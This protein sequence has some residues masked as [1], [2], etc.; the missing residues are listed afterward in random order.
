MTMKPHKETTA[1]NSMRVRRSEAIILSFSMVRREICGVFESREW[2][3]ERE[4]ERE[5][6]MKRD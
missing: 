4:R 1:I 5:R 6:E 3:V 2:R